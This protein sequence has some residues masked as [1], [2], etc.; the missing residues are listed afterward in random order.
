M[1]QRK[2][3]GYLSVCAICAIG[4]LGCNPPGDPGDTT[5]DDPSGASSGDPSGD[6]SGDGSTTETAEPT[7]GGTMDPPTTGESPVSPVCGDGVIEGD[8]VC[9]GA[10]LGGMSCAD[11]DPTLS[12]ELTCSSDCLT[13]DVSACVAE[14]AGPMRVAL[15][16]VTSKGAET[17]PYAGKGDAIE[18]YN[19]GGEPAD[20]SGWRLSDDPAFPADKTYVFPSGT[21]L[22]PGE[23][24]VLVELDLMT[25]DG[26]LP[27]GISSSN[28]E[29]LTLV[30]AGDAVQDAVTF[31]GAKAIV[32]WCRV[33]EGTGAW[34][35]CE[36]TFGAPNKVAQ[37][38]CGDGKREGDE[39]CDGADVGA[40]KCSDRG[41]TGGPMM[42]TALCT[43]DT[44]MCKSDLGVAL[45]ELEST[46]D[47][48]ELYNAGP[49]AVDMSG[50]ILTDQASEGGYK[51]SNDAEKLVF[52]A[53]TTIAPGQ[54]LV[55]SK[56]KGMMQH[57]FGLS[58]SGDTVTLLKADLTPVSQVTYGANQAALSFCRVTDGPEGSWAAGCSPTLGF[59]NSPP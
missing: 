21:T 50:W 12:G 23:R 20:L 25:G 35:H 52:P 41:F 33:P 6:P 3:C 19:A 38:I 40:A 44:S 27:F 37:T 2:G 54:F 30:D 24:L 29:T 15:N 46:N 49:E 43:L 28:T 9:D 8:E 5:A 4:L 11:V 36:Q 59:A 55:I 31:D 26:E 34:Q 57:P 7:G 45:N 14:P 47:A 1:V 13:L 16:E 39:A 22:A 10:A 58:S 32:S 48:I 51:P 56:G 53:G 17:G 42:C 18:L